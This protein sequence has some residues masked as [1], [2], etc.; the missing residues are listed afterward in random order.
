VTERETVWLGQFE[1][2]SD[3]VAG[4]RRIVDAFLADREPMCREAVTLVAS[5][6]ATNAVRHARTPYQVRLAVNHRVSIEVID[7]SPGVPQLRNPT[8]QERG[9][10][11]LLLVSRIA[12]AWG[13]DQADGAKTVWAE[14]ACDAPL[15]DQRRD[16]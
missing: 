6:L 7:A 5:E 13:V 10:R 15:S 8:P 16:P 9:G 4:V 2:T 1:P 11:G 3:S 12:A 14:V